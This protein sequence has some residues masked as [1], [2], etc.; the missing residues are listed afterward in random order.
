MISCSSPENETDPS[1]TEYTLTV[2]SGTGGSVSTS[3]G[4]YE[5]GSTVNV[6]ATPNS[7]YIFQNWSK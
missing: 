5:E 7:E 1:T 6:T 2:S 4:T 3:G